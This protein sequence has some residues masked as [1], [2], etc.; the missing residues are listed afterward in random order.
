[1]AMTPTLSRAAA[2]AKLIPIGFQLFTVR[3]EFERDVPGTL[4]ALGQ[5]GYKGV[6]FWGYGGAPNV[7]QGVFG[8]GVAQAAG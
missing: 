7:L 1:M 5:I 6:E 2:Q 4:K 3:G 8:G